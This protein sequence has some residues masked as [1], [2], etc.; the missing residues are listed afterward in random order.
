M[1]ITATELQYFSKANSKT[2]MSSPGFDSANTLQGYFNIPQ[3][4][5]LPLTRPGMTAIVMQPFSVEV[6]LTG[7]QYLVTSHISNSY[8]YGE[9]PGQALKNYFEILVEEFIWLKLHEKELSDSVHE[10]LRH[11]QKYLRIA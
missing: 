5:I 7:G 9:T 11:L 8:E 2:T 3:Y 4:C 1:S 10:D 6:K